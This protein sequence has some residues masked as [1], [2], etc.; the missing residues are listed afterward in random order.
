MKLTLRRI[1]YVKG[2]V[3]HKDEI[4][5]AET[6]SLGRGSDQNIFLQ[7]TRV[8]L[9]HAVLSLNGPTQISLKAIASNK[10]KHN[11][12]TT[13]S[14][15]LNQDDLIELGGYELRVKS[16]DSNDAILEVSEKFSDQS[17]GLKRRLIGDS[18]GDIEDLLPP[19]RLVSLSVLVVVLLGAS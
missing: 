13:N 4:L 16:A 19:K 17:L 6:L 9:E 8:A 7:N 2:A 12:Q 1:R 10:F 11:G 15:N 14:A 3:S 5:S 18:S